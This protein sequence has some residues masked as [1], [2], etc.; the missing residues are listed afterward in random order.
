M[1]GLHNPDGI[2]EFQSAFRRR[3]DLTGRPAAWEP[4][5]LAAWRSCLAE[6]VEATEPHDP[7]EWSG[8]LLLRRQ[9]ARRIHRP[10]DQIVITAGVRA[11]VLPLLHGIS[12]LEIETPTF[13]DVPAI[14]TA[15][16]ISVTSN[17]WRRS[18][19][20]PEETCYWVTSPARNPDGY[21]LG[22]AE[23]ATLTDCLERGG[24]IVCNLTYQWFASETPT[25]WP[26]QTV[27]VGS[28]HKLCGPGAR[29]GWV[30]APELPETT[31]LALSASAPSAL[32]QRAWGHFLGSTA[33]TKL[34][35]RACAQ[36]KRARD[37]FLEAAGQG[38]ASTGEGP[39]VLVRTGTD[40]LEVLQSL[41]RVGVLASLGGAFA[42]PADSLRVCLTGLTPAEA[43]RAGALV[44]SAVSPTSPAQHSGGTA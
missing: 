44:R 30:A 43:R 26:P 18:A 5:E 32:W 9:I 1:P 16:G 34:H 22:P 37:A 41:A 17:H 31:R 13:L 23:V 27:L 14:A 25:R 4:A 7:I 42:A 3:L 20:K 39:N 12:R 8:D 21:T 33:F 11:A 36:V 10:A 24:R 35:R 38:L 40:S 29:I 19:L 6:A 2:P 15:Y 28:L